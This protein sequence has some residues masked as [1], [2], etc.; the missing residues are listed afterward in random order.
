MGCGRGKVRPRG[1]SG[2]GWACR[3]RATVSALECAQRGRGPAP[4][5]EGAAGLKAT[6][7][8]GDQDSSPHPEH[9]RLC[10]AQRASSRLAR[11]AER[12]ASCRAQPDLHDMSVRTGH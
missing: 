9:S 12:S 11:P 2:P 3:E 7:A 8:G 1:R 5:R 6:R 4:G 10:A